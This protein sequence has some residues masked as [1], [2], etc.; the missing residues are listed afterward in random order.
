MSIYARSY[1]RKGAY[2]RFRDENDFREYGIL[3]RFNFINQLRGELT[4]KENRK[5]G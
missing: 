1:T 5:L 4:R 3:Q 2:L